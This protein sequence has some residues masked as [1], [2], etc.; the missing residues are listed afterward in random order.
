MCEID[1]WSEVKRY[2]DVPFKGMTYHKKEFLGT[3]TVSL[4]DKVQEVREKIRKMIPNPP[5]QIDL[6]IIRMKAERK[7]TPIS[8]MMDP[9]PPYSRL[10]SDRDLTVKQVIDNTPIEYDED[11]ELKKWFALTP[12]ERV[13][14]KAV[15]YRE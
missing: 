12:L 4:D 3:L 2:E 11:D 7:P 1:I 5:P 13:I 8:V 14:F 10:H 15:D 6:D 9:V